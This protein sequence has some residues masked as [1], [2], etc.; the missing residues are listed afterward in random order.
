MSYSKY[1]KAFQKNGFV[2][3]KNVLTPEI[4]E[5]YK[6]WIDI[7]YSGMRSEETSSYLS[8]PIHAV[9]PNPMDDS[10]L[11]YCKHVAEG[12]FGVDDLIPS[13]AY[14]REYFKGSELMIHRDRNA[15]QYSL[16]VTMCKRGKGT[17]LLWFSEEEDGKDA[18]YVDMNEGDIIVF[19]GG[20]EYGGKWHWREPLEL[21]SMVQLFLH[22]VHPD[23]PELA[24]K[25][26][27]MPNY[28]SR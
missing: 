23:T 19:N 9:M 11:L 6:S 3:I 17:S 16:T 14:S 5:L 28:R 20:S 25:S 7:S 27:P 4:L 13:Y 8:G 22:Y 21:D 26:F 24:D 18:E 1:R 10:L 12:V 2:R 15:C